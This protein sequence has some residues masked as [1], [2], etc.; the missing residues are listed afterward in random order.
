MIRIYSKDNCGF[1]QRAKALADSEELRYEVKT[2][3]ATLK[4]DVDRIDFMNQ[5]PTVRTMPHIVKV[6]EDGEITETIG[7]YTEFEKALADGNL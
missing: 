4:E 7:G 3:G 2:V 5:F 1:C 6:D